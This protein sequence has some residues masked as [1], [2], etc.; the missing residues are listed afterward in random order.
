MQEAKVLSEFDS[1][2]FQDELNNYLRDGW[3]ISSSS[4]GVWGE[5]DEFYHAI[6]VKN[7]PTELNINLTTPHAERLKEEL[8]RLSKLNIG[9]NGIIDVPEIT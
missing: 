1:I 5:G 8:I 4:S 2:K 3:S 6:L 7:I 9:G